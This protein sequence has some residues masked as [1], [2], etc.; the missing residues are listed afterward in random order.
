MLLYFIP[1]IIFHMH[2]SLFLFLSCCT[3]TL[4]PDQTVVFLCNC[5]FNTKALRECNS[6]SHIHWSMSWLRAEAAEL[7]P[8]LDCLLYTFWQAWAAQASPSTRLFIRA[9][10]LSVQPVQT[11]CQADQRNADQVNTL[12]D[13][14]KAEL[15]LLDTHIT[16]STACTHTH[17]D[18]RFPVDFRCSQLLAKW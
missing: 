7:G 8:V 14:I 18:I 6:T 11:L 2:F 9:F 4:N 16:D 5:A 17:T 12:L 1:S 15:T 3:L 10:Q 13:G